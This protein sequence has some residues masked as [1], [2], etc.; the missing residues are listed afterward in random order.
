MRPGGERV[1]DALYIR[2]LGVRISSKELG[3]LGVIEEGIFPS[4]HMVHKLF[5]DIGWERCFTGLY[6][7]FRDG[8]CP[9]ALPSCAAACS[10]AT[11]IG[12]LPHLS[13][14]IKYFL[15]IG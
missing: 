12:C 6:A 14:S 4:L 3:N 10:S 8:G 9:A 7:L 11:F 15:Q 2:E 1:E 5:C 13:N